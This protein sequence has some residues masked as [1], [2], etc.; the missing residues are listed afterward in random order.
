MI[1]RRFYSE[2]TNGVIELDDETL[3]NAI[4]IAAGNAKGLV[5]NRDGKVIAFG[6]LV[7]SSGP[8]SGSLTNIA[9]IQVEGNSFWAIRRDGTVLQWGGDVDETSVVAGLSNI[10]KI[11]WA[12]YRSYVALTTDGSLARFQIRRIEHRN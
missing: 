1:P 8:A 12:G 5:I 6:A 3:T 11:A 7:D 2:Q 9:R 4:A 10:A